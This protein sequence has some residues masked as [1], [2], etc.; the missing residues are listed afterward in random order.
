MGQYGSGQLEPINIWCT[1]FVSY[2]CSAHPTE[3]CAF[4]EQVLVMCGRKKTLLFGT[5]MDKAGADDNIFS[6]LNTSE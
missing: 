3:F 6:N 1:G 5:T 4:Q 2:H